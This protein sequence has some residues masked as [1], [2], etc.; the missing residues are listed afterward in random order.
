MTLIEKIEAAILEFKDF[1]PKSIDETPPRFNIAHLIDHTLLKPDAT[2]ADIRKLCEEAI[3]Y[4]FK[5]VCVNPIW[6][7]LCRGI[8]PVLSPKSVA[9]V[10]FPF[11]A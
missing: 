7:P 8:L 3:Q 4:K 2:E 5:S 1:K 6:I 9:V 10:D 11:G